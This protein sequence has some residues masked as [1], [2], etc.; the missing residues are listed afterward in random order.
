MRT[1]QE[2]FD[3]IV[4]HLAEQKKAARNYSTCLYRTPDGRSCAVGCLLS[5]EVAIKCDARSWDSSIDKVWD[6]AKAELILSDKDECGAIEFYQKMQN[7]H[8]D[9]SNADELR[10]RLNSIADLYLLDN[11]CVSS[12]QEWS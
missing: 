2:T 8:D 6:D 12:I 11:S 3:F 10:Q 5:D 7:A 1:L 9:S 4:K